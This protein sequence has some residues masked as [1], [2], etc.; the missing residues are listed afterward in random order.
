MIL[1]LI[2]GGESWMQQKNNESRINVVE[3]RSQRTGSL[4][5]FASKRDL[6]V[7]RI[8]AP[9]REGVRVRRKPLVFPNCLLWENLIMGRYLHSRAPQRKCDL[10]LGP[11]ALNSLAAKFL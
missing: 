8:A 1:A 6:E 7:K 9:R 3:M 5:L 2:Y 11:L 4:A 10:S